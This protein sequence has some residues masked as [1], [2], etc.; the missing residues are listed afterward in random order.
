MPGL[1]NLTQPGV[2]WGNGANGSGVGPAATVT[3]GSCHNPHGNGQYRILNPIPAP[4]VTGGTFTAVAAPGAP[5]LDSPADNPDA[6]ESDTKNYTVIQVRGT[7]GTNN[8]FLLYADDVTDS[9]FAS[10]TGD[11]FHRTVPWNQSPASP[12]G[13][14][15]PNGRPGSFNLQMTNW[16]LACHTRYM[17]TDPNSERVDPITGD[18][19]MVFRYQH[20]TSTNGQTVCTTCHVSHGSNALMDG[21]YAGDFP[22]PDD[23]TNGPAPVTSGSSRLLKVNNRGTCQLCHDPTNTAVVGSYSGPIPAPGIP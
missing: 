17:S 3:C 22:Y 5:I 7:Q 14:D 12:N 8:S 18:P 4:V 19:D 23:P 10:T 16:C 2:A 21:P 13:V 9:G 6:T 11:Y 1:A 15:A 20:Q